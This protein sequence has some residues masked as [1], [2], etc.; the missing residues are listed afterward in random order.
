VSVSESPIGPQV[1]VEVVF[2]VLVSGTL[3]QTVV[4]P[5]VKVTVPVGLLGTGSWEES[6]L[7]V[8]VAV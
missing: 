4:A 6:A 7:A 1:A 2:P 5:S 3:A 8:T